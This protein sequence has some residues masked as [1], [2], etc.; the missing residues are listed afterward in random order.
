MDER[1]KID[2]LNHDNESIPRLPPVLEFIGYMF[3]IA[4]FLI[5]VADIAMI[6]FIFVRESINFIFGTRFYGFFHHR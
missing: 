6:L 1:S 5:A 2:E 3:A 4:L